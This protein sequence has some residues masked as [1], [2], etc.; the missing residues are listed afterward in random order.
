MPKVKQ[1][2]EKVRHYHHVYV[3]DDT[4][5]NDA[6]SSPICELAT[7][8]QRMEQGLE[9]TECELC[10]N[11]FMQLGRIAERRFYAM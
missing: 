10:L 9:R 1:K 7:E 3:D 4:F 2:F 8:F 11:V 6:G 5:C